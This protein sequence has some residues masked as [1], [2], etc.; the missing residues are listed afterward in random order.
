[1]EPFKGGTLSFTPFQWRYVEENNG[2]TQGK[3]NW[4]N[5]FGKSQSILFN[6]HIIDLTQ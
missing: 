6:V 3:S 5:Q 4:K 1:M 2:K